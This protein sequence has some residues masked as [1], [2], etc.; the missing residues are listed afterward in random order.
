MRKVS[1]NGKGRRNGSRY[2]VRWREESRK[3]GREGGREQKGR[4]EKKPGF[5][6]LCTATSQEM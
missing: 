2:I 1:R 3:E 6:G 4:E 5:D